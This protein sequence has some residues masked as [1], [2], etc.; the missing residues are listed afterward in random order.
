MDKDIVNIK[1]YVGLINQV[2]LDINI[3]NEKKLDYEKILIKEKIE[4]SK[5]SGFLK[6]N[7]KLK[8]F[9]REIETTINDLSND[10][11]RKNNDIIKYRNEL[12]EFEI[13]KV[14][15]NNLDD[16]VNNKKKIKK[17]LELLKSSFYENEKIVI[18][19]I[20][21]YNHGVKTGQSDYMIKAHNI[22]FHF[23]EHGINTHEIDY[24]IEKI[25]NYNELSN[26]LKK[27]HSLKSK[28]HSVLDDFEDKKKAIE[29]NNKRS[30]SSYQ[31]TKDLC[32]YYVE[33]NEILKIIQLNIYEEIKYKDDE[34]NEFSKRRDLLI[35]KNENEFIY[36]LREKY[37]LDIF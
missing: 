31:L 5:K 35:K 22:F 19:A 11:D 4:L 14:N 37:N 27:H 21:F 2:K 33:F 12:I 16:E 20:E 24:L 6:F 18:K 1:Y 34:I 25:S 9:I 10:I 17:D 32:I 26:F 29:K 13:E 8:S 15:L 28:L 7:S 3:L 30:V 23:I 36:M